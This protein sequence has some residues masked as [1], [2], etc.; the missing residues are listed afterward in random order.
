MTQNT[1]ETLMKQIKKKQHKMLT[2]GE[3]K[4]L[5][6]TIFGETLPE[7]K[8]YK[9]TH[10]LKNRGY[11]LTLRKDI[12][13]IKDAEEQIS[14]TEL[15]EQFYRKLLKQHCQQYCKQDRYIGGMTALEIHL[16]STGVSIPEEIIIFNKEKQAIETILLEKKVNFKHYASK[17]KNLFS[18]FAKHTQKIKIKG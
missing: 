8:L 15:E 2:S 4:D 5:T 17:S 13:F 3:L 9:L 11:L 18:A 14:E 10:Q 16:H 7:N 12:F 6:T 1:S